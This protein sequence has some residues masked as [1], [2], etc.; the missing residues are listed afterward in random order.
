MSEVEFNY[1]GYKQI[2][3]C[4][5][6]D[7]MKSICQTY[8]NIIK[9]N[10]NNVSFSYKGNSGKNFN[11]ELTFSEMIN[12]ED[13]KANR[14][15][16]LV[17]KNNIK[18]I[19]VCPICGESIRFEIINYKIKFSKCKNRHIIDNILLKEF[20]Y[21]NN[22]KI[23]CDICNND[24]KINSNNTFY[25]CLLCKKN[26][27]SLC[28]SNHDKTHKII[29]HDEMFYICGKHYHTYYSYC[30]D[31]QINLCSFCQGEHQSHQKIDF[32]NI[33]PNKFELSEYK[34]YLENLKKIIILFNNNIQ[35]IINSLLKITENM[36]IYYNINRDIIN[37]FDYKKINY[38]TLYNLKQIKQKSIINELKNIINESS[39]KKKFNDIFNIYSNMNI[40]EINL[41]YKVDTKK[42][43]VR[44]FNNDFIEKNKNYCR[45]I[46]NG[47]EED[48]KEFITFPADTIIDKFQIKLKGIVNI[49]HISSMFR[50]CKSLISIPDIAKWDTSN[51]TN[52]S[53]MFYKCESL[54]PLPDIS[55]WNISYVNDISNMFYMC[56]SLTSLPDISK[57]N[58][59]NV[60]NLSLLF[61]GCSSLT[62]LPDISKWNTN[63]VTNMM[64]MFYGCSSL[65]S[66][67]DISKW[68]TNNVT[69]ISEM[70]YG[71]SSLKF[72]P[73]ISK[74]ITSKVTDISYMF[75]ECK[76]LTTLPDISKWD[77]TNVTN[78]RQ[79]FYGCSSLKTLPDISK[80]NITNVKDMTWMFEGCKENIKISLKIQ[81]K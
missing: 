8:L 37:N 71:C 81:D 74:W 7:K 39:I 40:N 67:P 12:S 4:N 80:W 60:N 45:T 49:T 18:T 31:C 13:K 77:T 30:E 19:I 51:I 56:N 22:K 47:I 59:S 36:N 75:Y 17:I 79:I 42:K 64:W 44:L 25:K 62:S 65:T 68:N 2:I 50:W 29:N 52:M 35:I 54:S 53:G 20:N 1:N 21:I 69:N 32:K 38:E 23:K 58:T 10:R 70:F 46:F 43:E 11:E 72:L 16:I 3:K 73:D 63:N 76:S 41:I 27:C 28:T 6:N 55:K 9:E 78:I 5:L 66:L 26:M 48:L 34:K 57:W 24:N 14:M 15:N 33:I 61:Y